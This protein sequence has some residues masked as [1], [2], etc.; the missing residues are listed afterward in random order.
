MNE[1]DRKKI[2]RQGPMNVQEQIRTAPADSTEHFDVVIVGRRYL[3][4]GRRLPFDQAMPRDELRGPRDVRTALAEP[5]D[6][7][8]S[9]HPLRQRPAYLRLSVQ[10]LDQR[11]DRDR[12]RNPQLHGRGHRGERTGPAH[13][14]S[15]HH[16]TRRAGRAAKISGP[17][18]RVRPTPA[19]LS[20]SPRISSGC[21]RDTTG[22]RRVI[23]PSGR[24]WRA[25]R[26][27]SFIRRNGRTI[28]T[29]RTRKSS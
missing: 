21:A 5:G 17:S 12:C 6:A 20:A 3:R 9:R 10:T 16:F 8:L 28:S 4:R 22:T 25:S 11:T 14:L 18:R 19:R 24:T 1:K 7:P 27:G 23:R 15:T 29:T 26:A 13:P 2:K